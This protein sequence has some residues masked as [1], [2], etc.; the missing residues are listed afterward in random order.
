MTEQPHAE[1]TLSGPENLIA[2]IKGLQ[3]TL[4]E[5]NQVIANLQEQLGLAENGEPQQ[6][7]LAK[8]YRDGWKAC[9]GRL[10]RITVDAALALRDIN[11]Q[12]HDIYREG[13]A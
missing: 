3:A 7:A 2:H 8:A 9:A 13:E 11:K 10:T 6:K 4:T 5:R 12:A 1:I